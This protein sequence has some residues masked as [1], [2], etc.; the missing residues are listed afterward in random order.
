MVLAA[1]AGPAGSAGLP[2][3]PGAAGNPG[4]PGNP[5]LPGP[6]GPEGPAGDDAAASSGTAVLEAVGGSDVHAGDTVSIIGGGFASAEERDG[7]QQGAAWGTW[8][9]A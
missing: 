7:R 8:R 2:G 3:N 1:C 5:G 6:A 9:G 4:A